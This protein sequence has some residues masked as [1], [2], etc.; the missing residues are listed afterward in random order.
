[1]P[2]SR[3]RSGYNHLPLPLLTPTWCTYE[4]VEIAHHVVS[5][6]KARK[7]QVKYLLGMLDECYIVKL[8]HLER[9]RSQIYERSPQHLCWLWCTWAAKLLGWKSFHPEDHLQGFL[10]ALYKAFCKVVFHFPK[11]ERDYDRGGTSMAG[12]GSCGSQGGTLTSGRGCP[13]VATRGSAIGSTNCAS[14]EQ[15]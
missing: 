9:D 6:H 4:A 8:P 11:V 13:A 12:R 3:V 5:K 1:M 10:A 7:W 15:Y 14:R 2:K